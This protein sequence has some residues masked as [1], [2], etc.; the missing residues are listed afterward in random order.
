MRIIKYF[1]IICFCISNIEVYS[2]ICDPDWNWEDIDNTKIEKLTKKYG[3]FGSG[4]PSDP[5][6]KEFIEKN[7]DNKELSEI[8]RHSWAT[9]KKLKQNKKQNK[10]F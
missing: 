7:Y 3:N 4:Y 2:Q 1:I 6:T 10:L 5:Y 9:V 8:I